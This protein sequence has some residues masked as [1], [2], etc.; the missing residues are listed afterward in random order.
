M[1]FKNKLELHV[2]YTSTK[3]NYLTLKIISRFLLKFLPQKVDLLA[4]S[5]WLEVF[6]L[7]QIKSC[8]CGVIANEAA[9]NEKVFLS[10][11]V[12]LGP[13]S[14]KPWSGI[15][16]QILTVCSFICVLCS[17]LLALLENPNQVAISQNIEMQSQNRFW[18]G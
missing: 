4:V 3:S 12:V 8:W 2:N 6:W 9:L 16:T 14:L 11:Y 18:I 1:L 7:W 17:L 13:K 5:R 10:E 15:S